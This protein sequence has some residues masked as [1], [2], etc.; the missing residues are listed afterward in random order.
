MDALSFHPYPGSNRDGLER[1][2]AWPNA[3]VADLGRIKLAIW[4]AFDGT[5]AADDRERAEARTSTRSA[6]RSTPTPCPATP[7]SENVPVTDE[8]TQARL[9][10]ELVRMLGCD[11]S[12]AAVNFFGFRDELDRLGFQ[13]GLVRAD[14]TVRPAAEAVRLALDGDRA[15][16]ASAS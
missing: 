14:G 3:G 6:G 7:A 12:V 2:Y 10:G 16:A 4:D 9:Y 13:A 15:A 8:R 1:G 5:R 11:P